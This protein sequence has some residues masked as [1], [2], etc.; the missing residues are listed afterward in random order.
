[1]EVERCRFVFIDLY[2]K[3]NQKGRGR[4]L[5]GTLWSYV[6]RIIDYT[7]GGKG[8]YVGVVGVQSSIC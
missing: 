8:G 2:L 1:M 3:V 5:Y 4:K 6:N 7:S